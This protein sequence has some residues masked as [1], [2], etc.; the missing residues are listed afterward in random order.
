MR[1][2]PYCFKKMKQTLANCRL[3]SKK[4]QITFLLNLF[5]YSI[6][7]EKS[8]YFP[9]T[10][11]YSGLH[12]AASEAATKAASTA[13]SLASSN[14]PVAKQPS[15]RRRRCTG[16][17][18]LV[19]VSVLLSLSPAERFATLPSFS[20]NPMP[21]LLSIPFSLHPLQS[22]FPSFSQLPI[23][24]FSPIPFPSFSPVHILFLPPIH[25]F[26]IYISFLFSNPHSGPSLQSLIPSLPRIPIPFLLSNPYSLPSLQYI[27][28]FF[29]SLQSYYSLSSI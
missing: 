28:Y 26:P 12:P 20:P 3:V 11:S 10:I 13:T 25:I 9:L 14:D 8:S 1:R 15:K 5:H 19:L 2:P 29:L 27:Q 16:L 22:L 24:L 21:V 4:E 7:L 23:P 6:D 17:L 18:L